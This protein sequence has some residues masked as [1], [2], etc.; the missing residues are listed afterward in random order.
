MI[1]VHNE[2]MI[3]WSGSSTTMKRY[4]L[5]IYNTTLMSCQLSYY[6]RSLLVYSTDI[7][8]ILNIFD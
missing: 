6:T 3:A 4:R 2:E 1:N 7:I 8:H 5:H